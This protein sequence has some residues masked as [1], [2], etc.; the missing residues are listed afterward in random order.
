MIVDDIPTNRL[1]LGDLGPV[2]VRL[3]NFLS[4]EPKPFDPRTYEQEDD[5]EVVDAEGRARMKLKV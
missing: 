5:D 4:I 2:Y 1:K 3:P